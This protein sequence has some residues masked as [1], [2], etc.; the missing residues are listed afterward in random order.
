MKTKYVLL[1]LIV[2]IS[3]FVHAEEAYVIQK[4]CGLFDEKG[5]SKFLIEDNKVLLMLSKDLSQQLVP[6]IGVPVVGTRYCVKTKLNK[7][8]EPVEI[9]EAYT[10]DLSEKKVEKKIDNRNSYEKL[11]EENRE[12]LKYQA[13][14]ITGFDY[15]AF[16]T[17]LAFGHFLS[18]DQMLL[19]KVGEQVGSHKDQTNVALQFK[20]FT[21][22]SFYIAPE[23]YY[24]NVT[25][26]DSLFISFSDDEED[27]TLI[28]AG[29]MFRIGN[30]WQWDNF[31]IGCD[32]FGLGQNFVYF[33]NDFGN[34]RRTTA[35]LLNFYIGLSW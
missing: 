11:S 17:Q 19:F 20:S 18:D 10:E 33:K 23:I 15:Q 2:I 6:K 13:L 4:F 12:G 35:T 8:K 5:E 27:E 16:P 9:T 7:K 14:L 32:W 24:L 3:S 30:Q 28:A 1:F 29:A 31:T 21:S 22:N 25:E 26:K 34:K